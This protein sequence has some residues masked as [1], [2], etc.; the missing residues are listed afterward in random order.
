[1]SG[2]NE[3]K[4]PATVYGPAIERGEGFW[5]ADLDA[6]MSV[7]HRHLG[8]C[9]GRRVGRGEGRVDRSAS[10]EEGERAFEGVKESEG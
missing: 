7:N 8:S 5:G 3:K 2:H 1:M 10:E 6:G 9:G 4:N